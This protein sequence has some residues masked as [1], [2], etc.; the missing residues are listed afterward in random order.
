MKRLSG[1]ELTFQVIDTGRK[2]LTRPSRLFWSD[3]PESPEALLFPMVAAQGLTVVHLLQHVCSE[4][5]HDAVGWICKQEC[6]IFS[7]GC[8]ALTL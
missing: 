1:I 7:K 6:V 5:G 8:G 2:M 3:T 4:R